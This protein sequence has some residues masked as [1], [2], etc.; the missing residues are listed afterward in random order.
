MLIAE[1]F[2]AKTG[3]FMHSSFAVC[4]DKLHAYK[5]KAPDYS[6]I[7]MFYL[8]EHF[9]M[10]SIGQIITHHELRFMQTDVAFC[11]YLQSNL[12]K[13]ISACIIKLKK[14]P[15]GSFERN[16][17]RNRPKKKDFPTPSKCFLIRYLTC[18]PPTSGTA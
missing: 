3:T 4:Q 7:N 9:V 2:P 8:A 15:R 14:R 11:W 18:A 1:P 17:D 6:R 16:K 13:E 10:L 5:K 12:R